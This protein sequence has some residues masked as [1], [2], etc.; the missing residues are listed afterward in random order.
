MS[1]STSNIF[2]NSNKW[3]LPM[4]Y[5][6]A[7]T[8]WQLGSYKNNPYSEPKR[9]K[10]NLNFSHEPLTSF[11]LPKQHHFSHIYSRINGLLVTHIQFLKKNYIKNLYSVYQSIIAVTSFLYVST[12]DNIIKNVAKKHKI[13]NKTTKSR[14]ASIW[15]MS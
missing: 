1:E 7:C 9:L 13:Y 14:M 10:S 8:L 2:I 5:K 11:L 3:H 12:Q 15:E 6:H 4:G